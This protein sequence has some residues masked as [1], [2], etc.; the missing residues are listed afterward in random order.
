LPHFKRSASRRRICD[1]GHRQANLGLLLLA[2]RPCDGST[3]G[4]FRQT[5]DARWCEEPISLVV[6]VSGYVSASHSPTK[7]TIGISSFATDLAVRYSELLSNLLPTRCAPLS[8]LSAARPALAPST[9][10]IV[11]AGRTDSA[12]ARTA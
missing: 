12:I 5:C 11:I 2:S 9:S 7:G 4:L 8:P 10:S 3:A 6:R 1:L